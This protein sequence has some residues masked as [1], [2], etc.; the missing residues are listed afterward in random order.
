MVGCDSVF[1][2]A[3]A[4]DGKISLHGAIVQQAGTASIL[5]VDRLRAAAVQSLS[6]R[7]TLMRHEQMLFAQAQQSAAC[8]ALHTV[9]SR[10]ARW[11][12]RMRDLTGSNKFF[13]TQDFLGQMLGVQ[14]NSVSGVANM[15][16]ESKLIRYQ[17]GH[18]EII[19]LEGV[20]N[21]SCECYATVKAYYDS[22]LLDD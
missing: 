20:S 15:L 2:S 16:Q 18:M 19:D 13:V 6:F 10:M 14:R 17:R 12:L 21:R 7:T 11:L 5:D 9:E 3:A 4:L 1:G 8:N 22:L